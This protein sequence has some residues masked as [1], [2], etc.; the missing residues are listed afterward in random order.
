MRSARRAAAQLRE[1]TVRLRGHPVEHWLACPAWAADNGAT[2]TRCGRTVVDPDAH[3]ILAGRT[4]DGRWET[5]HRPSLEC[6]SNRVRTREDFQ[7]ARGHQARAAEHGRQEAQRYREQLTKDQA[8]EETAVR[9]ED[10]T[11]TAHLGDRARAAPPARAR[12]C[13][14][15]AGE[16]GPAVRLKEPVPGR[17]DRS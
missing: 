6:T 11:V 13:T 8:A 9:A 5:R 10:A 7:A 2:C 3:Q 14:G 12:R 15:R 16:H 4:E 17:P 1:G